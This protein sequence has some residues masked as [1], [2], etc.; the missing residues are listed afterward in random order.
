MAESKVLYQY[1]FKY[2]GNVI[3]LVAA[4]L[5]WFPIGAVLL[6]QNIRIFTKHSVVGF[7]YQGEYLWLYLWA[8]L[9]F[10]VM[11]A[12]V[13]TNGVSIVEVDIQ[14]SVSHKRKNAKKSA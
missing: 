3:L 8:I 10:P 6:I 4:L 13:V 12:L 14:E 2:V 7:L 1:P 5:L 11:I 9:F